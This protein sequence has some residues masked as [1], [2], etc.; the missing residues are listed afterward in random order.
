MV[1]ISFSGLARHFL[2]KHENQDYHRIV[3]LRGERRLRVFW[4]MVLKL[5][6]LRGRL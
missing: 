2:E 1:D 4:N 5:L 3:T 6:C